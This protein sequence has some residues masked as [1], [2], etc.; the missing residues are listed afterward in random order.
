MGRLDPRQG[1]DGSRGDETMFTTEE[2]VRATVQ[3]R[4]AEADRLTRLGEARRA[5]REKGRHRWSWRIEPDMEESFRYLLGWIIPAREV[6]D[7]AGS[8]SGSRAA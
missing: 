5:R 2:L 4:R 3:E 7:D 6:E 8:S 1:R